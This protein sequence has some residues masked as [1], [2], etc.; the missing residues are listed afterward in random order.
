M[1]KYEYKVIN[2]ET[3]SLTDLNALG[4][5]G[6]IMCHITPPE[7]RIKQYVFYR[8]IEKEVNENETN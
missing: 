7:G 3:I 8:E 1:S 6:W 5:E 4:G 2:K